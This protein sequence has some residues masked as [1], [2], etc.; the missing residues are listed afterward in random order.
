LDAITWKLN[1][2]P[3][4]SSSWKAATE[5]FLPEGALNTKAYWADKLG[6]I[7]SIALGA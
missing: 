4:K 3:R 7:N 1:A 5:L 2:R 6:I